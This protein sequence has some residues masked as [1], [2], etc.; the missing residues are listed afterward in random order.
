MSS[1]DIRHSVPIGNRTEGTQQDA[2]YN[3]EQLQRLT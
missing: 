3:K 1:F 2:G